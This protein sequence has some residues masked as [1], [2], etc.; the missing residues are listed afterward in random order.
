MKKNYWFILPLILCAPLFS[1]EEE[2]EDFLGRRYASAKEEEGYRLFNEDTP[3]AI[4][5]FYYQNH[6]QQTV[7]FVLSKRQ[8]YASRSIK[9][10]LW[11][12]MELLDAIVDESDPDTSLSQSYHAFQTAE[13]L[14]KDGMPRWLIL[15]G[16]IHDLGKV[17][18]TYGEPQWAVVGD[19]FPVGCQPSDKI[20]FP[21][22]F[23]GNPDTQAP[24]YQSLYGIY[25]P[26]CGFDNLLMSWG[27]DEYLYQV[28]KGC[29]PKEALYIIRYHS[30]YPAHRENAYEY[31]MNAF[32]KEMLPWLKIFSHYD[33]YSKT[34]EKLD[35]EALR[36][37]YQELVNE[38]IPGDLYW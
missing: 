8:K 32:D 16:L 1:I 34:D 24:Q 29:L 25:K 10:T 18:T 17:L 26:Y 20:V 14:R 21:E 11:E 4:K 2:W 6:T 22:Y 28:M 13:A 31:F 19:T 12:A 27:H 15:T 7:D 37:Y 38:F 36:P 30:F 9:M 3:Q 5:D 33:L 35:I 23:A